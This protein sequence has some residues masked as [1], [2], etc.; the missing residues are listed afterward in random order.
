MGG[1][2]PLHN[3]IAPQYGRLLM[4]GQG[5]EGAAETLADE[6]QERDD[7]RVLDT[8]EEVGERPP[9]ENEGSERFVPV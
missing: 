1:G 7:V 4:D 2:A 3:A 6:R 9:D 8:T 5:A